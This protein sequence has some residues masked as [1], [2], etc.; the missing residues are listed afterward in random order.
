MILRALLIVFIVLIGIGL[1]VGR[2]GELHTGNPTQFAE[3]HSPE[4]VHSAL[5]WYAT[6]A[7][8]ALRPPHHQILLLPSGPAQEAESES[9]LKSDL[10]LLEQAGVLQLTTAI[11]AERYQWYIKIMPAYRNHVWWPGRPGEEHA[12]Y[13]TPLLYEVD[14]VQAVVPSTEEGVE[15]LTV[16][17]IWH[18]TGVSPFLSKAIELGILPFAGQ[19]SPLPIERWEELVGRPSTHRVIM[20]R[21]EYGYY[22]PLTREPLPPTGQPQAVE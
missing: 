12:F 10:L 8:G 7:L 13:Y 21:G 3:N 20:R 19:D 14:E 11:E 17:F 6:H 2:G 1:L 4:Q 15:L 18:P 9:E 16:D 22:L 5:R